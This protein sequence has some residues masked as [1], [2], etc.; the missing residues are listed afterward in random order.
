MDRYRRERVIR[1]RLQDYNIRWVDIGERVIRDRLQD[2]NIRSPSLHT[3]VSGI[4]CLCGAGS[5]QSCSGPKSNPIMGSI[6]SVPDDTLSPVQR[7]T[8]GQGP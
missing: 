1:D 2:Y 3:G 8:F 7:T 6:D 5:L 4:S